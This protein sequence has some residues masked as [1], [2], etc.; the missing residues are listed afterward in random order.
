MKQYGWHRWEKILKKFL[1]IISAIF[2]VTQII[3]VTWI[4]V[5]LIFYGPRS[6]NSTLV[7][8][9]PW[10]LEIILLDL[11]PFLFGMIWLLIRYSDAVLNNYPISSRFVL[12]WARNIAGLMLVGMVFY[13]IFKG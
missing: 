4:L 5:A 13:R 12:K 10:Q 11:F 2:I 9:L 3:C 6:L 1:D 7:G 8:F